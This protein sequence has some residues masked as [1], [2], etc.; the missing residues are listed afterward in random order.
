LEQRILGDENLSFD[1]SDSGDSMLLDITHPSPFSPPSDERPLGVLKRRAEG[2]KVE[3]PLTPPIL[4]DSPMKKLKSVSFTEILHQFIPEALWTT[5]PTGDEDGGSDLNNHELYKDLEPYARQATI[6]VENERLLGADTTARVDVP[7][8]KF[9]IPVSPWNEHSQ[10]KIG[11]HGPNQSELDAQKQFLLR[12]KRD[13]LKTATSWHGLSSI[14][15]SM[16]WSIFTTK[17]SKI[18]LDEKL[19]GETEVG[20]LLAEITSGSIATSSSQLWKSEGLRILDAEDDEEDL[21]PADHKARIDMD[22]LIRKRK[23][24]IEEDM[25]EEHHKRMVSQLPPRSGLPREFSASHHWGDRLL[26]AGKSINASSKTPKLLDSV[27]PVTTSRHKALQEPKNKSNDLMFGGFSATSALHKFMKTRG[28]TV[29]PIES[30]PAKAAPVSTNQRLP[31]GPEE[32][33]L[34]HQRSVQTTKVDHTKHSTPVLLAQLPVLPQ[35]PEPCSFIISST[36]LQQRYLLKQIEQL[37]RRADIVYRDYDRPHSPCK[38]ADIVLSPS[39]GLILTTLQKI[40]Q[41]PL[42]GRPD[43]SQTE[44]HVSMLQLRYERL[45]VIIS[46]GL[47]S[48][49]ETYGSSRPEDARDK[50]ALVRFEKFAGQLECEVIVK[51][52]PGGNRALAHSIVV[53][54]ANY[55]LR[56]GSKDIGDIK[57]VA[58]ETTVS[59]AC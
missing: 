36:F 15:R 37:Y 35:N 39:T 30:K 31:V 52:I 58:I 48:E 27:S 38:E 47:N 51:Y 23:L 22:G 2:L 7:N 53:E 25:P 40:K 33:S 21:E 59:T 32:S 17:I 9:V 24:E 20:K 4:S 49:M 26:A 14:E 6:K 13:D 1:R 50:E 41:R 54:M 42:P 12:I 46:E 8:I 55:G 56:H 28:K 57:P 19:H 16:Q 10:R 43:H 29:V 34:D 3:G 45:L 18:D 5:D 11:K 44:D